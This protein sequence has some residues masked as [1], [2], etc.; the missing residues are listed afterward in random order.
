MPQDRAIAKPL[1]ESSFVTTASEVTAVRRALENSP[2]RSLQRIEV[3]ANEDHIV[4]RGVV[5]SFYLKQLAQTLALKSMG[6]VAISNC[7][8]VIG[9]SARTPVLKVLPT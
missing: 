2:Y 6:R 5:G 9:I 3:N 7:L 1:A 4:L 8:E